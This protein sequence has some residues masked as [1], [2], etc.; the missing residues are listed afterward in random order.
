MRCVGRCRRSAAQES[1]DL[2]EEPIGSRLILQEQMVLALQSD[3]A[4]AWNA[5]GQLATC[6]DRNHEITPCMHYECRRLHRG[7]KISD[8]QI[9]HDIEISAAHSGE[10]VLRCSSLKIS[11]CSCVPPGINIPVNICRKPG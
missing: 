6:L 8:I 10:V 3:E 11:A 1:P 2:F 4:G 9:A 5:S 7:E